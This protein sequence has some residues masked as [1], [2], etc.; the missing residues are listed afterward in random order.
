MW[1][2]STNAPSSAAVGKPGLPG[3]PDPAG[4]C[5]S[6]AQL[7]T[8]HLWA[9]RSTKGSRHRTRTQDIPL[10]LYLQDN[11]LLLIHCVIQWNWDQTSTVCGNPSSSCCLLRKTGL[12]PHWKGA[13]FQQNVCLEYPSSAHGGGAAISLTAPLRPCPG[14]GAGHLRSSQRLAKSSVSMWRIHCLH[15]A[16]DCPSNSL[17]PTS[18]WW[19][20]HKSRWPTSS[21]PAISTD[22]RDRLCTV[23][24]SGSAP[25]SSRSSAE[26]R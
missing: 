3:L 7:C 22:G 15:L 26:L 25:A 14:T 18:L 24:Y 16:S 17:H 13:A 21:T 4:L 6:S 2:S 8:D 1:Q 10:S 5:Q 19:D 23:H 9:S 12:H 20:C 11:A